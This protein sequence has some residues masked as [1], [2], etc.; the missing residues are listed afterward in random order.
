M[1]RITA[2]VSEARKA[3][4][5]RPESG[6]DDSDLDDSLPSSRVSANWKSFTLPSVQQS[7]NDVIVD[8][9]PR[10]R[11]RASTDIADLSP[12]SQRSLKALDDLTNKTTP[13]G[14]V[15]SCASTSLLRNVTPPP[16]PPRT[17]ETERAEGRESFRYKPP[18]KPPR[19]FEYES[20]IQANF[21][22]SLYWHF[23]RPRNQIFQTQISSPELDGSSLSCDLVDG[24]ESE[25]VLPP[26]SLHRSKLPQFYSPSHNA[27]KREIKM[28]DSLPLDDNAKVT[29]FPKV[30][31]YANG[32]AVRRPKH[33]LV[34]S[35]GPESRHSISD[36]GLHISQEEMF[37]LGS[38]KPR[39]GR[40]KRKALKHTTSETLH[41]VRVNLEETEQLLGHSPRGDRSF[42]ETML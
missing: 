3:P 15:Q 26:Y 18:P 38:V 31:S 30:S 12:D 41:H 14:S 33:R 24:K 19:T 29:L 6:F 37:L 36:S 23:P 11:P 16:K 25:E 22:S 13:I 21:S 7:I 2:L 28:D 4:I 27:V 42:L 9:H 8:M 32:D 39:D 10:P 40:R 5:A 17:F 1:W 20:Q 34:E 35:S